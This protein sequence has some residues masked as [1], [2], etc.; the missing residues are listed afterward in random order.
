MAALPPDAEVQEY[1][2]GEELS[3]ALPG[4]PSMAKYCTALG[5]LLAHA[6]DG[7][8]ADIGR[9]RHLVHEDSVEFSVP[10]RRADH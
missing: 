1:G 6:V 3:I 4:R 8:L 2:A 5:R 10:L 9:L 7:V